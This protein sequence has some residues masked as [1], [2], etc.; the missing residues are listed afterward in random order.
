MNAGELEIDFIANLAK[1][2][3]DMDV[4]A[5]TVTGA[6]TAM[7]NEVDRVSGAMQALNQIGG[8]VRNTI[9]AIGTGVVVREF[10]Q[11]ADSMK[12]VEARIRQ[13]T[14]EGVDLGEVQQQLVRISKENQVGIEATAGLYTK[15]SRPLRQ[16]GADTQTV[17][18]VTDA[19]G[20]AMRVGGANATEA[21][22]ATQ[23]FAQ[24]MASGVLRGDEFNSIAEASPR[25]LQAIAE[26]SGI[27]E[28]ALREMAAQGQLTAGV[29]GG[30]LLKQMVGLEAEAMKLPQTV[31]GSFA[32]FRTDLMLVASELN[33]STELTGLMG[34][35]L[36]EVASIVR[37]LGSGAVSTIGAISAVLAD[38]KT[39]VEALTIAVVA[40]GSAYVGVAAAGAI[41]TAFTAI[42]TALTAL[43]AA[44]AAA[45]LGF[46]AMAT[47]MGTLPAIFTV[48]RGAAIALYASLG[49][50]GW[51][52]AGLSAA[53]GVAA[54]VWM[55]HK[56]A[57][58]AAASSAAKYSEELRE[59]QERQKAVAA[60]PQAMALNDQARQ[61]TEY[62]KAKEAEG[63][64]FGQ[65]GRLLLE[66]QKL[67]ALEYEAAQ[68]MEAES[69]RRAAEEAQ[70]SEAEADRKANARKAA[71]AAEAAQRKREAEAKKALE[72]Q[73]QMIEDY[74]KKYMPL[75][76]AADEYEKTLANIAK[77]PLDNVTKGLLREG[78]LEEYRNQREE[79]ERLRGSLVELKVVD[80]K[81][82]DQALPNLISSLRLALPEVQTF[83]DMLANPPQE[84]IDTLRDF[85]RSWGDVGRSIEN[86]TM[87]LSYYLNA[88]KTADEARRVGTAAAAGDAAKLAK[89]ERDY[90]QQK[91]QNELRLYGDLTGAAKEFFSERSKGYKALEAVEKTFRAVQLAM[92]I[93]AMVQDA[94]ETVS[95]ITN[96]GARATADASAAA[97]KAAATT[98]FPLSLGAIAAVLAALAAVGVVLGGGGGGGSAPITNSGTGTVFGDGDAKSDSIKRSLDLLA[99][100]DTDMLAVS[101][102]MLAS[103]KSIESQL[104]GVTNLVLRQGLD[105]VGGQM[106]IATGFEKNLLGKA[107]E[108][109]FDP[110]GIASKIPILGDIIGGIGK[111]L[112]SLFGTKT[113][114]VGSGIFGGPQS[115]EDIEGLGF[116]GQ[117]Y[118]D[119]KKT[120]KFLGVSTSKK[121]KTQ[122][123]D[124]DDVLEDQFG[125]L[126]LSFADTIRLAAGPLGV[127]LDEIDAK[128]A[129]FI[130]DIGKIDLKDLSGEEI[131]EKLTAVFGAQADKMA[132]FV[133]DLQRF[134]EVGEGAFET[135]V[136]VASTVEAVTG[137]LQLLGLASKSLGIDASM[138]IADLFDS[139]GNYQGAIESYFTT[140][141]SEAEQSAAKMAQLGTIFDSL[142]IAMPDSIAA[143]RALVEAQDLTTEGGRTLYATLIQLAPA[144]ASIVTAGQ[145]AASAAA[146]LR[147]RRDLEKQLLQINGDTAALRQMEI[148]QLDPS[149]KALLEQ[150]YARQD[151]IAAE[152]AAAEAQRQAAQAAQE[153]ARAAE[154]LRQAWISVADGILAEV[155]RIR[156]LTATPD[157]S[158]ATL[159]RQF[160]AATIAARGGNQDAA[161]QLPEL[162]RA[163]LEAAQTIATSKTQLDFIEAGT[164]ASLQRTYD[165]IMAVTNAGGSIAP[166]MSNGNAGSWWQTSSNFAAA[167]AGTAQ[168]D[169]LVSEL[170]SVK[171]ELADTRAQLTARLDRIASADEKTAAVLDKAERLAAANGVAGALGTVEIAA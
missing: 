7:R 93:K 89:V 79:I 73:V 43:M 149:N 131:Q 68:K 32:N 50:V 159:Q 40:L 139:V 35:A 129:G 70:R 156:G 37:L 53:A 120:K 33:N 92:S 81:F 21:A 17:I 55:K 138:G 96:S 118:A 113:K 106:N 18:N 80:F 103:L 82:D 4:A 162:S 150:I 144:F 140:F 98:P 151:Q 126:I 164:A 54:T 61:L 121:Y 2:K 1:L 8:M 25:I 91:S 124:L 45:R 47:T 171:A 152:Q 165:L 137:S 88:Q 95:S 10:V 169:A 87:S 115:I 14:A 58:D 134:Q 146:I 145:N 62:R 29:V 157:A 133:I 170:R 51:I 42:R 19:F 3:N 24:A 60:G 48:V 20:K 5:R 122:F 38:N 102:Q 147:E 22:A 30:A 77:L 110:L 65:V 116:D 109:L 44:T 143:F 28:G 15:L 97:A 75:Q 117:T 161:K 6:S 13:V 11:M 119:I 153:A 78:A 59:L 9:A 130:V 41:V 100:L 136:R 158:F 23:Q 90:A 84:F 71:A 127:G 52:V 46:I 74:T 86:A 67:Q 104:G 94:A 64:T 142:G 148:D 72:D 85:A 168:N 155:Q 135:L 166:T 167:T 111:V 12:L 105:D 99:D 125:K 31:S 83:S 107:I 141:Y 66:R 63:K 26:G 101:R 16:L 163:L 49:P 128:L 123:G 36:E 27:A 154:Q 34:S 114:V 160:D 132:S 108:S 57:T 112:G 39:A 69:K 56:S 76:A